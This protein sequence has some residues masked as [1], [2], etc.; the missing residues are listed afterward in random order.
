[1]R[2]WA[3]I[4]RC[5]VATGILVRRRWSWELAKD[6]EVDE[7]RLRRFDRPPGRL[8]LR[9]RSRRLSPVSRSPPPGIMLRSPGSIPVV[10]SILAPSFPSLPRPHRFHQPRR[11]SLTNPSIEHLEDVYQQHY[12][13]G[14]PV[15]P[16]NGSPDRLRHGGRNQA[17][18]L[19][20]RSEP[21]ELRCDCR[22]SRIHWSRRF[23]R[24][25]QRR[26]V[27][28]PF[29]LSFL[30]FNRRLTGFA[31]CRPQRSPC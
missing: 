19:Q 30:A 27:V 24:P 12:Q 4:W 1:M 21:A 20:K 7:G 22:R 13:G 16:A 8:S 14:L 10:Y 26:C 2:S 6:R 31:A 15:Q 9:P 18:I 17:D 29:F 23:S 3:V 28:S 11:V 25:Y 5:T